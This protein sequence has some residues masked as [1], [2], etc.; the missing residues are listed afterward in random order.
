MTRKPYLIAVNDGGP[1]RPF[2]ERLA[3]ALNRVA[4]EGA[5]RE[6]RFL[7][8]GELTPVRQPPDIWLAL[9]GIA[10]DEGVMTALIV[11][12]IAARRVPATPLGTAIR[13]FILA[14]HRQD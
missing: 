12:R 9:D 7:I 5:R 11:E 2:S 3:Y 6:R 8:D 1:G 13:A 4:T 10:Q 14:F